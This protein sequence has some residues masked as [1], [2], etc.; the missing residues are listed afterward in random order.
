MQGQS[1]G[2]HIAAGRHVDARMPCRPGPLPNPMVPPSRVPRSLQ[3]G[4]VWSRLPTSPGR[5]FIF[6]FEGFAQPG[7]CLAHPPLPLPPETCLPPAHAVPSQSAPG[8]DPLAGGGA[9]S[10]GALPLPNLESCLPRHRSST[11]SELGPWGGLP[12]LGTGH[13][14][15]ALTQRGALAE[16][17]GIAAGRPAASR[18]P[19]AHSPRRGVVS[20]PGLHPH[21]TQGPGP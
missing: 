5:G 20:A 6:P 7:L 1:P 17:E 19:C 8:Y 10:H 3:P 21:P 15:T 18:A 13:E 12:V 14:C 4:D 16:K 11:C 2:L 9:F